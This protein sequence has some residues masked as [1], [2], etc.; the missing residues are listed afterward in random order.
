[1]YVLWVVQSDEEGFDSCSSSHSRL[2]KKLLRA[3]SRMTL[4]KEKWK[5]RVVYIDDVIER[6]D[7]LFDISAT[8]NKRRTGTQ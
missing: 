8:A 7:P 3:S 4:K 1:M 2:D 5:Q 6:A